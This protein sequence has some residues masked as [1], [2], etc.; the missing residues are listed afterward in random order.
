MKV[1]GNVCVVG[2]FKKCICTYLP[3]G[4]YGLEGYELNK[5]YLCEK[6]EGGYQPYWRVWLI[7]EV[8]RTKTYETCSKAAFKKY[9]KLVNEKPQHEV[10]YEKFANKVRKVVEKQLPGYNTNNKL[11]ARLREMMTELYRM[12]MEERNL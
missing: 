1:I 4:E 10:D 5:E 11:G 2:E 12:D 8:M 3:I 6:I 9:F 7:D